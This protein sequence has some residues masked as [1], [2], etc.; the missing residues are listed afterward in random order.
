MA[1]GGKS[2]VVYPSTGRWWQEL[3]LREAV[4]RSS[5]KGGRA[6]VDVPLPS[7]WYISDGHVASL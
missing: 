7:L 1:T 5:V 6:V 4:D 3:L 2:L